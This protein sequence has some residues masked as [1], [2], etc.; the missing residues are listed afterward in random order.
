[1]NRFPFVKKVLQLSE[2]ISRFVSPAGQKGALPV[3][4]MRDETGRRTRF[5]RRR[6]LLWQRGV[7]VTI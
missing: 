4:L 1:M 7:Y 2:M 6:G 5:S 3:R